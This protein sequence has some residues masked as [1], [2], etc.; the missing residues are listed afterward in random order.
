MVLSAY[1]A[2]VACDATVVEPGSLHLPLA[3]PAF[4]IQPH[5]ATASPVA[6]E[7]LNCAG[8]DETT[9]SCV[10]VDGELDTVAVERKVQGGDWTPLTVVLAGVMYLDDEGLLPKQHCYRM[11]HRRGTAYTAYSSEE[12]AVPGDGDPLRPEP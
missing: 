2:V 4:S 1:S 5:S 7:N 12:C 8:T 10:W 11:R 3:L 9:I 6:P